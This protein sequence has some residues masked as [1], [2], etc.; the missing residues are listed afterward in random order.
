M[1]LSWNAWYSSKNN[2]LFGLNAVDL[3]SD[4]SA[5]YCKYVM[6]CIKEYAKNCISKGYTNPKNFRYYRR[7]IGNKALGLNV[8]CASYRFWGEKVV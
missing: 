6:E 3:K 4:E 8:G 1:S 7:F 5:N 2:N